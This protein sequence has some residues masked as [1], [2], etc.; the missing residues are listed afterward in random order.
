MREFKESITG[1]ASP[2]PSTQLASAE[3]NDSTSDPTHGETA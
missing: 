2:E 3:T 1:H